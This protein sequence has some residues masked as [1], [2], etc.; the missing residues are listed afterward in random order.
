VPEIDL[1][2]ALKT[3]VLKL[4]SMELEA[5]SDRIIVVQDDFIS[6][7]ECL[8]C[9]GEQEITCDSC[10]G[11]GNSLVVKDG[12]CSKCQGRKRIVCPTCGG[13]GATLV[14]PETAE[15]RPT[16]GQILSVGPKVTGFERGQSVIYPSFAGHVWDLTALD[17]H[18]K[19]VTVVVVCLRE[20]EVLAKVSG[21]LELR[22]VRKSAAM[23]T[24][25]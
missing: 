21:H 24:A 5:H 14:I 17:I 13:K 12:K 16:T 15:R 8:T 18:G 7:Y 23:S 10:R 6:G 2:S 4:G 3:N 25:A 20:D 19:E 11:T 1:E 22:R 9:E